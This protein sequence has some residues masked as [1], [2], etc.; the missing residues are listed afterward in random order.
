MN[1]KETKEMLADKAEVYKRNITPILTQAQEL[2]IADAEG[3]NNA[4]ILL[5]RL[6]KINDAIT[7]EKEKITKPLNQALRVERERWKLVEV[8]YESTIGLVKTKIGS[9][10]EELEVKLLEDEKKVAKGLEDGT[11]TD[12][13]AMQVLHNIDKTIETVEGSITFV[14]IK[15]FEVM[16]L[17]MLPYE[18]LLADEAMIREAM[19]EG[20]ELPG[21]RYYEEQTIRN[22]R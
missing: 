17:T 5:S 15:K 21:V 13:E 1:A 20:K 4:T 3:L 16:D 18:Y 10:Y 14:K 7:T 6:N 22:N 2:Y 12:C 11:I 9:Y 8:M 19:N